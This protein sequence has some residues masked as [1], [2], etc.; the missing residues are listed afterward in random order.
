MRERG[1]EGT[2]PLPTHLHL[3]PLRIDI[4]QGDLLPGPVSWSVH[5]KVAEAAPG[6]DR[7]EIDEQ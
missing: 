5:V 1:R 6:K 7:L 3:K 4:L 2:H